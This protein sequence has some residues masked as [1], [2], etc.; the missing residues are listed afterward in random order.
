MTYC[1]FGRILNMP[2]LA[3]NQKDVFTFAENQK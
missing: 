2:D 3:K 1:V